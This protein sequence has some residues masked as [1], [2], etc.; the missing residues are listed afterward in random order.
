[1]FEARG[2]ES[3]YAGVT[4]LKSLDFSVGREVF[5]VLGANGAGKSTLLRTMARLLRLQA[6][7]MHFLD[8]DV[9]NVEPYELAAAGL[10][11]V[12]QEGHIFPDL[13]V[14]ENLEVGG[15][16]TGGAKA[17]RMEEVFELW[18]D[19]SA[20]IN[21]KAGTLSGGEA[22]MTAVG[23]ALMQNPT[24]LLLDEPTA[25]LSPKYA[26]NLFQMIRQIHDAQEI[27]IVIAEQNAMKTLAVADRVMVLSLGAVFLI[28]DRKNVNME[29]LKEGYRI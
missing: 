22:Q 15:L 28:D 18:P 20:R 2:L 29:Q 11:Y 23:R 16:M 12:P 26:D 21:Q 27:S 7:S 4:V 10:A 9:S 5:A 14:R 8:Q 3:G 17:D 6:G 24:L 1:M 19:L 25:G 13:T